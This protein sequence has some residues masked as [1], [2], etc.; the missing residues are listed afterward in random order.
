MQV[1]DWVV[2]GLAGVLVVRG[3][4]RG[5]VREIIE[6]GVL[7]FGTL[8]VFRFSPVIGTIITG[9][10]NVPYEVGRIVGGAV[11]FLALV[12]GGAVVA[13]MISASLKVVPGATTLNRLGGG[14]VGGAYAMVI[15]VLAT[16][17]ISAAPMPQGARAAIDS[18]IEDSL[19]G[20]W[21]VS[22]GGVV[23]VTVSSVSGED[24]FASVI[25][26]RDAVGD[27]L[28]AGTLPIAL[29]GISDDPLVPSQVAA[30]VVF[31]DVNRHRIAAG[32]DPLAWSPDLAA[33][34]TERANDVYRSGLLSL[35]EGLADALIAAGVPGTIHAEM[36]AVAATPQGIV[37]ALSSADAYEMLITDPMFRLSGVGVVDGPYGLIAVQVVSG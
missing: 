35:D 5:L 19:I 8:L 13:R 1:Y 28:A 37:E 36:V 32:V 34:A 22:P 12:I 31:D 15:V 25:A 26:V 18:S 33:V 3:W 16:T 4:R 29:P 27:R 10:A 6:L 20:G 30:Q 17:L 21:I 23:Q 7:V 2:L 9:M 14:L 11:M 24:I